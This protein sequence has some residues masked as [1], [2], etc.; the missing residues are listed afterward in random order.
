MEDL[1]HSAKGGITF[2][3]FKRIFAEET[4]SPSAVEKL[5]LQLD[6]LVEQ[7]DWDDEALV[8]EEFDG[9]SSSELV[10]IILYSACGYLCRRLLKLTKC[11]L[12]RD[13]ILTKLSTENLAVAEI[14]NL[15]TRGFLLHCNLYLFKLFRRAE[16]FFSENVKF[17]NC[18]ERTVN[19]VFENLELSFPCEEHGSEFLATS[20]HYYIVI[21][22]RHY[23]RE[24]NRRVHKKSQMKKKEAKLCP[25]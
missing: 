15:K 5:K 19:D 4:P 6:S 7:D 21:R 22:L 8:V 23:E 20:L 24:E 14:V 1:D 10:D 2:E 3:D 11:S 16:T 18:Y 25:T 13:A 9:S 12:C 17:A